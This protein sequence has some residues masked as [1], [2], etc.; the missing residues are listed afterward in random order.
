MEMKKPKKVKRIE[1]KKTE[2]GKS[3]KLIK[4]IEVIASNINKQ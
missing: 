2:T 4:E 3:L 1:I